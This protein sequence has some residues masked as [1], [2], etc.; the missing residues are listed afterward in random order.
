LLISHVKNSHLNADMC[1]F[2]SSQ[3]DESRAHSADSSKLE[4]SLEI[5]FVLLRVFSSLQD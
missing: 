3:K 5:L 2:E 4:A 1:Q